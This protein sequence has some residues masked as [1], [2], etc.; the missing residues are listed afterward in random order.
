MPVAVIAVHS[1]N[2]LIGDSMESGSLH[3][4]HILLLHNF[5]SFRCFFPPAM[6][7]EKL[8]ALAQLFPGH[9]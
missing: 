3:K 8:N 7:G 9:V 5:V 1:E 6:A 4:Q 2:K